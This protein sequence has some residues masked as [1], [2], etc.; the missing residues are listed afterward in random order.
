MSREKQIE[1]MARVW[2]SDSPPP[3]CDECR[4]KK[5]CYEI[6][7]S[8]MLYDAG[9]RKQSEGEWIVEEHPL[10]HDKKISCSCCGYSERKGPVWNISWGLHS[11]CPNCGASMKGGAEE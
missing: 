2:C 8:E 5:G 9:Y 10:L 3:N 4:C 7:K 11:F 1:E 6:S